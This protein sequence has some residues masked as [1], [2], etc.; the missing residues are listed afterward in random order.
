MTTKKRKE[1]GRGTL[2]R[3]ADGALYFVPDGKEWAFR[4]PNEKTAEARTLLDQLDFVA[5]K[6]RL[7]TFHGSGLV[8]KKGGFHDIEVELNRLAALIKRKRH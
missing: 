3:G 8:H 1:T 7:P 2:I 5:K 6:D 4:L